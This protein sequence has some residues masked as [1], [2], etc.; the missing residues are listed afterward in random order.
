MRKYFSFSVIA[1]IVGSIILLWA[2]S[3]HSYGY[4]TL[5]RW[6]VCATAAY[7]A[8]LSIT[9]NKLSWA[10]IFG[11]IALLFNPLIPVRIDRAAWIYLDVAVVVVFLISTFFLR[12]NI[13]TKVG[14]G[15]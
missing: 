1:R 12:E 10:W 2:L 3:R 13:S 5:L 7:S 6:I 14:H 8:F 9:V 15:E 4:F 11:I